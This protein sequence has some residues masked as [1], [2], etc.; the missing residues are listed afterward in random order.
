MFRRWV[1]I[2]TLTGKMASEPYAS[3]KGVSPITSFVVVLMDHKMPSNSSAYMAFAPLGCFHNSCKITL[4]VALVGLGVG[5]SIKS[6][7]TA[8]L[9]KVVVE[10]VC[11][12]MD[13]LQT[14]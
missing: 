11:A 13:P 3:M 6:D 9:C 12:K 7:L 5:D 8:I 2:A 1:W 14:P 10:L 4:L